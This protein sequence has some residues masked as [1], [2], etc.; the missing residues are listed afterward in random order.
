MTERDTRLT[1][2]AFWVVLSFFHM[3]QNFQ[4]QE[5]LSSYQVFT[6]A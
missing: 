2:F 4:L 5:K 1:F 6:D 3:Q